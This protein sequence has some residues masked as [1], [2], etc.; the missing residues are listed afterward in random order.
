MRTTTAVIIG[1]LISSLMLPAISAARMPQ[2]WHMELPAPH[3][4][5]G[6]LPMNLTNIVPR[7]LHHR[8]EAATPQLF[9]Y[10]NMVMEV[11]SNRAMT[12]NVSCDEA[13]RIRYLRLSLNTTRNIHLNL[14]ANA[15][16]PAGVERPRYGLER[17]L[18]IE[19]NSTGPVSATMELYINQTALSLELNRTIM[20]ER[21]TWCYW[22]GSVWEPVRSRLRED[23][24]LEAN[25]T[26]F[27]VWTI[28]E[29][30]MP[31][32]MPLPEI[33]GVPMHTMAYNYTDMVPNE[34]QLHLR[35]HQG[36]LFQFKNTA[37]Y[38]NCTRDTQLDLTV[39]NEFRQRLFRLE[40][41]PGEA[42][43]L[44]MRLRVSRPPEVEE[45]ERHMGFYCEI[46]PNATIARARLGIEI[47]PQEVESRGLVV[48]RLTWAYWNGTHWCPVE[49]TLSVDN[50]LEAETD[51]F[52]VWSV[53]EEA[54]PTPT[55]ET[56]EEPGQ[57]LPEEAM[58][59]HPQ[60]NYL[61]Y[62]AGAV[63]ILAIAAYLVYTRR[64]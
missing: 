47:D 43:K 14:Q 31:R 39:E 28:K 15:T 21:L 18:T 16:P 63:A 38:L 30:R 12:M 13:V 62:G 34:F 11:A 50:I 57:T 6:S 45:P 44:E 59:E 17:Y 3:P 32:E 52:S 46:E 1:L 5:P 48:E 60:P 37:L 49:S 9:M 61:L 26:H 56:V 36:S 27:S 64:P 24:F 10:R 19:P 55:E 29:Q 51:H 7:R 25:T 58:E 33:S 22:N 4:S 54:E 41:H 42:L 53:I 23:G 40:V 8:I 35:Q 20:L 2:G